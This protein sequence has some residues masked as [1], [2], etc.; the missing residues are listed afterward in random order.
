MTNRVK[1][2]EMRRNKEKQR[3]GK[4]KKGGK[5]FLKRI[6]TYSWMK[7]FYEIQSDI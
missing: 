7:Y 6:K 2:D 3:E 5:E 1:N 4:G